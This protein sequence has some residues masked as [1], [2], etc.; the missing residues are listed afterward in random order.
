MPPRAP[1]QPEVVTKIPVRT[2][3]NLANP[4]TTSALTR[5]VGAQAAQ[6]VTSGP[7]VEVV[8]DVPG[9]LRNI[10]PTTLGQ[11]LASFGDRAAN[12]G[13]KS[14]TA[15]GSFFSGVS[16]AAVGLVTGAILAADA[17]FFAEPAGL[18][19]DMVN[20]VKLGTQ[21]QPQTQ[22]RTQTQ[23]QTQPQTQPRTQTQ[24]QTQPRPFAVNP[25]QPRAAL[26]TPS[27]ERP[28]PISKD[29][30]YPLNFVDLNSYGGVN[31]NYPIAQKLIEF[32]YRFDE[33]ERQLRNIPPSF[34]EN[35]K[36]VKIK[37]TVELPAKI[38]LTSQLPLNIDLSS[39]LPLNVNSF[40]TLPLKLDVGSQIP[41]TTN[42]TSQLP[43]TINLSKEAP[44]NLNLSGAIPVATN[45]SSQIPL[46]LGFASQLP[47]SVGLTSQL[48]AAINLSKE[49]PAT[50]NL[51]KEVPVT[52]IATAQLPLTIDLSRKVPVALDVSTLLVPDEKASGIK[53]L[54]KCCE[55]IQTTLKKKMEMF[56]GSGNLIC[57][58]GTVPYSY[59]GEGLN[60][61]HQALKIVLGANQQIL[62]KICDL[63]R[64]IE[65]PLIEGSGVYEC[66]T[67]PFNYNYSGRGFLGI[68]QQ[69]EQLFNLD[70]NI[71]SEVCGTQ[72][73]LFGS[74]T[75]PEIAGRI[76]Y[77]DC[78]AQ[79]Q[80][81]LYS[82]NGLEGLSNQIDALVEVVKVGVAASCN[83]AS[84]VIMPD[85]RFENFV[86]TGQ[87][88]I[89]LG[90]NYPTQ[91]SSL[92]HIYLPNPRP[93]YNWCEDFE[94]ISIMKGNIYARLEW[95]GSK[96]PTGAYFQNEEE[97][98]RV[99]KNIALLSTAVPTL[100]NMGEPK[101][102][103]GKGNSVKR[104]IPERAVRAVRAVATT[105]EPDGKVASLKC[106]IPPL[107]GCGPI[108][109]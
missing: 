100:N 46:N 76:E 95:E 48:P 57:G 35:L 89:T 51:S 65:Y 106:Y 23:T 81:I 54:Q 49:V 91:N 66:G 68:Q 2:G 87:L 86:P 44:I 62:E 73:S 92:W 90:T 13:T 30:P 77:F 78:D 7:T 16:A 12:I 69:I 58:E 102:F 55:A 60:G 39:K 70:K 72:S 10:T 50:I 36:N 20:G 34:Q 28:K 83:S 85:A 109:M 14:A 17:T 41:I 103:I 3:L 99:L 80:T 104:D 26:Q 101:V 29:S 61:I 21:T 15:V 52:S 108:I 75:F 31:L 105:F 79:T 40:S 9:T 8:K 6:R 22:P 88:A 96:I 74:T 56:E 71:L 107:G 84:T 1:L 11:K 32:D 93:D 45:I 27:P 42:L 4:G 63:D 37:T 67:T 19:S 64:N 5:T 59:R 25:P 33:I 38:D 97:A 82:G 94:E 24:T 98:I 47:V 53:D 18:G 43:A